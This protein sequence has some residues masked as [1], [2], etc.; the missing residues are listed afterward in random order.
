MINFK[1]I[2]IILIAIVYDSCEMKKTILEINNIGLKESFHDLC[3]IDEK[4]IIAYSYGSGLI[5]KSSD[6]GQN[7]NKVYQTDS[8]WFEQIEFPSPEIGYICGNTNKILKTQNRGD[9]WLELPIA[10]IHPESHFYG[11]KFTSV[12]TGYLAK[13]EFVDNKFITKI[14]KTIDGGLNWEEINEYPHLILNIDLIGNELWASGKNILIQNIDK[15]NWEI[16]Y[17]DEKKEVGDIRAF[18]VKDNQI[19]MSSW[20]GFIIICKDKKLVSKKQITTNRLR[21]IIRMENGVLYTAGDNNKVSGNL[22]KSEDNGTTWEKF[23]GEFEDI[24]RLKTNNGVGFGIGK[25]DQFFRIE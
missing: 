11:M 16:I 14:L 15:Q 8:I 25:N 4:S 13:W 7:W 6:G 22:F 21:T 18:V 2:N 5:I 17:E 10:S 3:P 19:V 24:H 20:N 9:K 23:K 1:L 12:N